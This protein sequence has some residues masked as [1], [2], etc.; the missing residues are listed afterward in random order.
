MKEGLILTREFFAKVRKC[1]MIKTRRHEYKCIRENMLVK[2]IRD[3]GM[4]C[5]VY[6]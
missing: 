1:G 3:D 6:A 4:I 2:I 5:A